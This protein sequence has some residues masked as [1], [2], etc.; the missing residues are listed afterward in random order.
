LCALQFIAISR[1]QP[2]RAAG[3]ASIPGG[4]GR[5][6]RSMTGWARPTRPQQEPQPVPD[7]SEISLPL[8]LLRLRPEQAADQAICFRLFC[9]SRPAEFELLRLAAADFDQLMQFQFRAQSLGYRGSF[10]NARFDIIELEGVPIGRIVVDR[11]GDVLHIVDQALLPSERGRGIGSA[12]MRAL[13]DEARRAGLPV[14]LKVAS[15]N[16]PARRLYLRLGFVPI[17]SDQQI[18]MEMEWTG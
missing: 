6:R 14:R 12:I 2:A 15:T 8:G 1:K 3:K 9:D 18:F 5:R 13:M 17:A 7:I 4:R 11:P 10:P 16:A